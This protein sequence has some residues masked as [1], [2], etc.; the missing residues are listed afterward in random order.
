MEQR[1]YNSKALRRKV[2]EL[3]S[4]SQDHISESFGLLRWRSRGWLDTFLA[5]KIPFLVF[6]GHGNPA[7]PLRI[8]LKLWTYVR[9]PGSSQSLASDSET[10]PGW[11]L[12]W[13]E[14]TPWLQSPHCLLWPK[15]HTVDLVY[16]SHLRTAASWQTHR[17]IWYHV[18]SV[19]IKHHILLFVNFGG[20]WI[21]KISLPILTTRA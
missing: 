21:K 16:H 18:P 20:Q 3:A 19:S 7:S 12:K 13:T 6:R 1:R 4:E 14:N 10:S 11:C 9:L 15:F 8:D 2:R 17:R 5:F